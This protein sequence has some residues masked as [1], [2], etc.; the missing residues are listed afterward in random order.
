MQKI[1]VFKFEIL[2]GKLVPKLTLGSFQTLSDKF[3]Q[4]V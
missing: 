1:Q 4:N 3:F 2:H